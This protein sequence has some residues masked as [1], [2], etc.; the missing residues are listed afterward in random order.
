MDNWKQLLNP[1]SSFDKAQI[2]GPFILR[3]HHGPVVFSKNTFQDNISYE[4]V[5]SAEQIEGSFIVT[6]NAFSSNS[7][8]FESN[9]ITLVTGS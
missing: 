8:L 7:A 5:I 3:N 9:V 1:T 6:E 4:G 2:K